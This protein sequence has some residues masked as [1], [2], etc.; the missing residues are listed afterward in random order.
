MF[1]AL[2]IVTERCQDGWFKGTSRSNKCG[3]FPGNYV[4]LLRNNRENN[5]L[6]NLKRQGNLGTTAAAGSAN[7]QLSQSNGVS[8]SKTIV[9]GPKD[10]ASI[11]SSSSQVP[12]PELPPRSS[13]AVPSSSKSV[14]IKTLGLN[15]ECFFS[16]KADH[17]KS[18]ELFFKTCDIL[19]EFAQQ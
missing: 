10:T 16:P 11:D 5:K 4:A 6:L 3:V 9:A 15:V 2:Y 14:W 17:S 18:G 13:A 8:S 1:S 19:L 12:P 7:C